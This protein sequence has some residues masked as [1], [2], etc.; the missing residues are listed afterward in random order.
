MV[1]SPGLNTH[2]L[3]NAALELA[4]LLQHLAAA[5]CHG[6]LQCLIQRVQAVW[7]FLAGGRVVSARA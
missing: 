3:M 1:G 4:A 2:L 5:A 6:F 7:V